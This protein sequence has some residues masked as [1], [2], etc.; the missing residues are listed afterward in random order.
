MLARPLPRRMLARRLP[1]F[2]FGCICPF[3]FCPYPCGS[4]CPF[5]SGA[6]EDRGS[7]QGEP[8]GGGGGEHH[9][10][11]DASGTGCDDEIDD[12]ISGHAARLRHLHQIQTIAKTDIR[13]PIGEQLSQVAA[14]VAK[15]IGKKLRG[16]MKGHPEVCRSLTAKLAAESDYYRRE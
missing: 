11:G 5:S 9:G 12:K 1:S 15:D 8:S 13:G 3:S 10:S 14:N 16:S 2:R 4:P 7:G 6:G